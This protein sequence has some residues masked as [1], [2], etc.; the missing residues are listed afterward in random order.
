LSFAVEIHAMEAS[1]AEPVAPHKPLT[2][3]C[4]EGEGIAAGRVDETADE[5]RVVAIADGHVRLRFSGE[6]T[7]S[8]IGQLGH[9]FALG[10]ATFLIEAFGRDGCR[11]V[12]FTVRA[13]QEVSIRALKAA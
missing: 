5:V 12:V 8:R 2:F 4:R 7:N 6:E 9:T 11:N 13:A 10:D 3:T 1:A